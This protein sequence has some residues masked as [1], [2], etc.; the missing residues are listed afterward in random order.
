MLEEQDKKR[1]LYLFLDEG[2]NLDFS[3]TGTKYFTLTALSKERPFEAYKNLNELKYDLIELG[4]EIAYFH[5][6]EDRQAVRNSVFS[7]IEFNLHETRIDSLIVE[8]RKTGFSLQKEERFYPEMLG[9]LLSYVFKNYNLNEFERVIVFT[10]SIPVQK[11]RKAIEKAIKMV[12]ANKLPASVTYYIFHHPSQSNYDLQI[13]DYLNWAVFRKW[14][15]T[16]TRSYQLIQAA[17][18]SE[19]DIFKMG[20]TYYY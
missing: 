10:D 5:A 18:K 7:I 9:Y 2:G 19:F 14:G 6:S 11:K 20:K 1:I 12:L 4:T 3:P 17:V 13:V 16:D 15:G 8:K